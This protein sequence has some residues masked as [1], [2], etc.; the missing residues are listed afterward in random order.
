MQST[1]VDL[2]VALYEESSKV[3]ASKGEQ[4]LLTYIALKDLLAK[5][6]GKPNG[7]PTRVLI[8]KNAA[9][10]VMGQEHGHSSYRVPW[11]PGGVLLHPHNFFRL[12]EKEG[13][14]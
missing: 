8:R 11:W 6:P 5:H 2:V 1:F 3:S 13:N 9:P 12:T 14:I 4:L 10:S 7:T